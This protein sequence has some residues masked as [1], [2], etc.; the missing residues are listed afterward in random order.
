M[1]Y[2]ASAVRLDPFSPSIRHS[3]EIIVE[4]VRRTILDAPSGAAFIAE[5]CGLMTDAGIE[6][7]DVLFALAAHH[8]AVGRSKDALDVLD[9]VAMI[10]PQELQVLKFRADLHAQRGEHDLARAYRAR[11]AALPVINMSGAIA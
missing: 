9:Q 10:A 6:D 7:A 3:R 2:S 4:R 1:S 5:Y 8:A 11:T